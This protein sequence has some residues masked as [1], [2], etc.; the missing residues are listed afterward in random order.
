[1]TLVFLL[2]STINGQ[3]SIQKWDVY[4]YGADRPLLAR[5]PGQAV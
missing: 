4:G 2:S 3:L 5:A 1:M